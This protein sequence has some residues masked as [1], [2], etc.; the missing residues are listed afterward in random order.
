MDFPYVGHGR[1]ME[2]TNVKVIPESIKQ[3]V[4]IQKEKW[5]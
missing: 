1:R 4:I 2:F 3:E 5:A